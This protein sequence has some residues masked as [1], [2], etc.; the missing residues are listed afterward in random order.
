MGEVY[1]ARDTGL[2]REVAIKVLPADL[3]RDPDRLARF[4]REAQLL[5]ALNHPRIAAIHGLD[6]TGAIPFLVLELVEGEDLAD[7]LKRGPIPLEEALSLAQQVAEAVEEAH[8]HGIVHR[9]LKP[10]NIKLTRDGT[11]KVLDFGLAKAFTID[12]EES[13]DLS[14]SPTVTRATEYG[15]VLGTAPYMSPEQAR[16][17]PVDARADI[18]AFGC[19]LY[20]MLAGHKAFGAETTTDTLAAIVSREPE[21]DRLPPGTPTSVRRLLRRCLAKDPRQRLHHM[22]D[23]RIELAEPAVEAAAGSQQGAAAVRTRGKAYLPWAL[24]LGLGGALAAALFPAPSP[25]A[26]STWSSI[27]PP[28]KSTFAYFAGPVAVSHDASSLAFVAT[29]S[30]GRDVAW[31]RPLGSLE[32]QALPGTEGASYPFWSGDDRSIGFFAGGKLKTVEVKGGP[33]VTI[34]DAPGARGGT[35]SPAGV[36]LFATTWSGIHR[37]PSSGGTPSEITKPDALRGEMSHR[38]PYFLPDGNHFAYLAANF[39]TGAKETAEIH[40][41]S[42]D[43]RETKLLLHARSNAAFASGHLLF[44]RDRTLMAQAFDEKRLEVQGQAFPI[45]GGVQFDELTW[46]GVFACSPKGV[47]VYQGGN[48]GA[49]S[50]MVVLDRAGKEIKTLGSPADFNNHRISPDG[51][52]VAIGVLDPSVV[53]FQ[54]WIYEVSQDKETR[55]T[56]G[57]YRNSFPVWAP[58]GSRVVFSSNR[59]GAWDIIEKRSD[60]TGSEDVVLRSEANKYPS[61]WS[62]DGRFIVYSSTGHAGKAKTEEWILPR[63]GEGKPH[64]FLGGDFNYGEGHFSPDGRWLVY[65]SDESGRAEVYV[66]PFP[67]GGN[68]WQVSVAGG[69]NPRWRGDGRELFYMAANSDLMAAEVDPRESIFRVGAVR[70]LFRLLLKT[71]ASRLD[72]SPTAGQIG[73]DAAPDGKWFLVNSPPAGSPPPLT[74]I[75]H[76]AEALEQL[77]R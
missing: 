33:V 2:S 68:K 50:R 74:L 71:G 3:T 55:L 61:D 70:P 52:R 54:L 9:D 51:R 7:R 4:K 77:P 75:T 69:S 17:R 37:V 22:A 21:W 65:S 23:A 13:R 72:L 39:V 27:L 15:V 28:E 26:R 19:V 14:H 63:F 29:T 8:A 47:L 57:P 59:G 64:V 38:W 5:A 53:N 44:V 30:E 62:A 67:K 34:C 48:A 66:T 6:Q 20:E 73:Y 16:G 25:L 76:W 31:V 24:A 36:I 42:L 32:A 60:S 18:W 41:G 35:W 11:V 12:G 46:R 1:R 45:A 10:A 43:S 58:D 40:L 49:N 56:F